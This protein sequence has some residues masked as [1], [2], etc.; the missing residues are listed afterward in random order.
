MMIIVGCGLQAIAGVGVLNNRRWGIIILMLS[1]PVSLGTAVG[2]EL[3]LLFLGMRW[4]YGRAW[5]ALRKKV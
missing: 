1:V 3:I 2:A 4:T 5:S